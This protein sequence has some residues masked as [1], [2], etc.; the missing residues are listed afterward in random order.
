MEI[1]NK[2]SS[3]T[4]PELQMISSIL[5]DI[6]ME[7]FKFTKEE[8]TLFHKI[9]N[10]ENTVEEA[11]KSYLFKIEKLNEERPEIFYG[12][13]ESDVVGYLY[14]ETNVL[15]N[16]FGINNWALLQEAERNLTGFRMI[17][18]WQNPIQGKF[19]FEHLKAIHYQFFQDLYSWAGKTR[20]VDIGKGGQWF[21]RTECLE[22]YQQQ[23]FGRLKKEDYLQG[24]EPAEFAKDAA[25]FLG[26]LNALHP[27]R[28]GNGRTQ[29]EFL[30]Q[31][32][33]KAGYRL[34][35]S[36]VSQEYMIF[37][38]RESFNGNDDEFERIIKN[39]LERMG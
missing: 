32:A 3:E 10:G 9:G 30:R 1:M 19:D 8:E 28:E 36:D 34:V 16:N 31:L 13:A 26:D 23:I 22:S 25:V 4:N 12:T 20:N 11:R 14:P 21:C 27:F 38:S 17:E 2:K 15:V 24:L 6:R 29:R 37:A 39:R 35:L 18:H 5:A 7:G 33:L